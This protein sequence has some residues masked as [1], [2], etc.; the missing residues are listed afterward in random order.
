MGMFAPSLCFFTELLEPESSKA[1][2][3]CALVAFWACL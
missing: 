2:R 3:S 1:L